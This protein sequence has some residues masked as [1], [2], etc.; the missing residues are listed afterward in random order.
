MPRPPRAR[1]FGRYPC[2]SALLSRRQLMRVGMGCALAAI[3]T[4]LRALALAAPPAWRELEFTSIHTGEK[5]RVVYRVGDVYQRDAL[6]RVNQQL[7]DHRTGQVMPIDPTLLDLLHDLRSETGA[8]EPFQ[9]ISG[10]RTYATNEMLRVRGG[11][12]G[13]RSYHMEGM[14][15]DIRVAD[16]PGRQLRDAALDLKRGGVGYYA[17]SNFVHVD[18]GPVRFW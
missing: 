15:I 4:P 14:A 11:Q 18:V 8:R 16:V 1:W 17:S 3:T 12:V 10:Y 7:R 2:E 6:A 9:V 13:R 5:L